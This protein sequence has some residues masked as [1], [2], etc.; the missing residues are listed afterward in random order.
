M[1]KKAKTVSAAPKS[2]APKG[3]KSRGARKLT[4]EQVLSIVSAHGSG[5]KMAEL[6]RIHGVSNGTISAIVKGRT[7]VWLTGIGLDVEMK[8]AA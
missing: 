7:Y 6:A 8:K 2:K 5:V 4:N 3:G 1:A